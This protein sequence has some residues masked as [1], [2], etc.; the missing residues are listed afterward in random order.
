MEENSSRRNEKREV[1]QQIRPSVVE[2][3]DFKMEEKIENFFI[4]FSRKLKC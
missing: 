1:F 2:L 4:Y 3:R